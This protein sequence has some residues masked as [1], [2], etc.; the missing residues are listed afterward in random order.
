MTALWAD[1]APWAD[2]LA[3]VEEEEDALEHVWRRRRQAYAETRPERSEPVA[4]NQPWRDMA[5]CRTGLRLDL[6]GLVAHVP[7]PQALFFPERGDD[8]HLARQVCA[9]CPVAEDC[10]LDALS[11]HEEFGVWGGAGDP[12]R[13]ALLAI[14]RSHAGYDEDCGC[15]FCSAV[16]AHFRRLRA[17]RSRARKPG[18][19]PPA[20]VSYGQG[21]RCG[22]AAKAG[23]GCG[24][25]PCRLAKFDYEVQRRERAR[26]ED[27]VAPPP[28]K[29]RYEKRPSLRRQHDGWRAFLEAVTGVRL[30]AETADA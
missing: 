2:P 11:R 16:A 29:P 7:I 28:P 15:R 18:T 20:V 24:C 25:V 19:R 5:G 26:G 21:A 8:A 9:A 30:D 13:R 10:L 3:D 17:R 4:R 23:R 12:V 22:T 1:L 27:Y 6:F 14:P